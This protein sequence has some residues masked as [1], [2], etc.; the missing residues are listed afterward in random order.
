MARN[1]ILL[2]LLLPLTILIGM[3]PAS[4]ANPSL[5]PKLNALSDAGSGEAAYHLGMI[6]HVGAAGVA[7]DARKAFALFKLAAERGDPMGAYKYGCYFAGQGDG[8]VE[9]DP[10]LAMRYKLIAAEA[11]YA[12]AQQD[13]GVHLIQDGDAKAGQRWLEAAAAQGDM[14]S[15]LALAGMYSNEVPPGMARLPTNKARSHAF[16][17]LA[18]RDMPDM[19]AM[20][21]KSRKELTEGERKEAQEIVSAW[22]EARSP[23][24][25]NAD[26]GLAAAY[27]LAGLPVPKQ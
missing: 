12:L 24:T 4:A 13:V 27:A 1:R 3:A 9:S 21:D 17:E 22:R 26:R 11:G 25:L 15:L 7:K 18:L 8:I 10:K 14:M 6:H 5:A 2:K 23:L 16:L 20:L 19:R